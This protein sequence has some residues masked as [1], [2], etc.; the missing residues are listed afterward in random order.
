MLWHDV[1]NPLQEQWKK[2][3]E[4]LQGIEDNPYTFFV[5]DYERVL[6]GREP[7]WPVLE[8]LAHPDAVPIWEEQDIYQ[9]AAYIETLKKP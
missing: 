4:V 7:D 3:K 5:D 9:I 2:T 6:A 8:A 1:H